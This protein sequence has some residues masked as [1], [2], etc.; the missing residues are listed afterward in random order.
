M[1]AVIRREPE[2]ISA[3][4]RYNIYIIIHKALRA[5]MTDVLLRWGR[6]D[7]ADDCERSEAIEQARA[8]LA[9]CR[10]H[11]QHENDFV[12]PAIER[13]QPGFTTR[14]AEEHVQHEAEI[15]HLEA[16]LVELIEAPAPHRAALAQRFYRELS[17]FVAENFEHM[18]VEE[19]ENHRALTEAYTDEEILQIEHAIVASLSPEQAFTDMRWM[20]PHINASERAFMLGGMKQGAPPEVFAGVM[21][22]ARDVLSQ[23]DYYK[24]TRALA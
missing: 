19:T 8:L 3:R 2:P 14:L 20:I 6:M 1:A 10:G 11:L 21:A 24:L 23:R 5:F 15:A 7:V 17:A 12:H 18:L 13:A 16:S 4:A 9:M 22:L